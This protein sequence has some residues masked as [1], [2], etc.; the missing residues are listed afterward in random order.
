MSPSW[1]Q[2]EPAG[3]DHR[4]QQGGPADADQLQDQHP[5]PRVPPHPGRHNRL[6]RFVRLYK[7]NT[8]RIRLFHDARAR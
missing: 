3:A 7:S 8:I 4:P 1:K 5:V 6:S 2:P